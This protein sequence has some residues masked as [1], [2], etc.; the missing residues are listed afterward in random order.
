MNLNA[1]GVCASDMAKTVAFYRVL[2]FE[3]P[4]L[5]TDEQHVEATNS[6]AARLMIDSRNLVES[7]IGQDPK[8]GNHSHFAVQYDSAT[9]VNRIAAQVAESGYTLVKSP[10]DAFWGQ[11]YAVVA[12][13][14]GYQVDLYA[15]L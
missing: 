3:F 4:Q 8:P 2:G 11:R 9:E 6:G 12:D 10:W 15:Q 1:V 14:D 5:A 13:P 7:L